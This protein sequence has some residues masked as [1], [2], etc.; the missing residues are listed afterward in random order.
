MYRLT[1]GFFWWVRM[2]QHLLVQNGHSEPCVF[3]IRKEPLIRTYASRCDLE[4]FEERKT[5]E[6]YVNSND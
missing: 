2:F 4:S 5:D 3:A 1:A 6:A